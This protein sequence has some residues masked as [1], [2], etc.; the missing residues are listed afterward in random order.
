MFQVGEK[1]ERSKELEEEERRA[2]TWISSLT[3][4]DLMKLDK[5]EDR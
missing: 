1:P 5:D 2:L 4:S 3:S